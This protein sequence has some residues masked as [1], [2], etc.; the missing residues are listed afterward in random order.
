MRATTLMLAI[1]LMALLGTIQ[2][3]ASDEEQ[4]GAEEIVPMRLTRH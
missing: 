3:L 2:F 1:A 4:P